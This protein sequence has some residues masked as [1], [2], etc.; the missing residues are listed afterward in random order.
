MTKGPV[1]GASLRSRRSLQHHLPLSWNLPRSVFLN[2]ARRRTRRPG[3]GWRNGRRRNRGD[4][5]EVIPGRQLCRRQ[6]QKGA[7]AVQFRENQVWRATE[8]AISP[9]R[10]H[11]CAGFRHQ[12]DSNHRSRLMLRRNRRREKCVKIASPAERAEHARRATDLHKP[13]HQNDLRQQPA[14]AS[15]SRIGEQLA[16][17]PT[18]HAST[19][20]PKSKIVQAHAALEKGQDV[21]GGAVEVLSPFSTA[22]H[23]VARPLATPTPHPLS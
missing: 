7:K 9:A 10:H 19:P 12:F 21:F 4:N 18:R 22:V 15:I 11:M 13:L 1:A 23:A 8:N 6:T 20:S 14:S 2:R 16:S 17:S 5:R 3:S